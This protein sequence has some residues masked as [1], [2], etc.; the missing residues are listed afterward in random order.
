M[1][2]RRLARKAGDS[3]G[4][5]LCW[6]DVHD[7]E[8][9]NYL[10]RVK[11]EDAEVTESIVRELVN[12]TGDGMRGFSALCEQFYEY[13]SDPASLK[14]SCYFSYLNELDRMMD[15]LAV[16]TLYVY[17]R[18]VP[19]RCLTLRVKPSNVQS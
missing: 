17:P 6:G 2:L 8:T 5:Q 7:R 14:N 3:V 16:V 9:G 18:A 10:Y 11:V 12:E 15:G 13:D 1:R 19:T 4:T